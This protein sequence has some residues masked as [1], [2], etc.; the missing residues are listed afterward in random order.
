MSDYERTAEPW[1]PI[2]DDEPGVD[3]EPDDDGA[4]VDRERVSAGRGFY[5]HGAHKE[6]CRGPVQPKNLGDDCKQSSVVEVRRP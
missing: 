2:P 5:N 3:L 1:Y 4:A 6:E